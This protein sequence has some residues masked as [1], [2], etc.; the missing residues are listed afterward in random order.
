MR[1]SEKY[2]PYYESVQSCYVADTDE[3][4]EKFIQ[5]ANK[6]GY[7]NITATNY[8]SW[9][10]LT[11]RGSKHINNK[12]LTIAD[13]HNIVKDECIK[14]GINNLNIYIT[15]NGVVLNFDIRIVDFYCFKNSLFKENNVKYEDKRCRC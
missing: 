5:N 2:I 9:I 4:F 6:L 15:D 12:M 14:L 3:D 13:I 1:W 8:S 10:G 11:Y 7:K